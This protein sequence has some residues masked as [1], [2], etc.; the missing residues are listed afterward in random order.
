MVTP[1]TT[2]LAWDA[3]VVILLTLCAIVSIKNLTT[4]QALGLA[5][6]ALLL[7]A[8]GWKVPLGRWLY[9][10]L[11][12]LPFSMVALPLLFN[13]PGHPLYRIGPLSLT[14]EG[15]HDFVRVV[16]HCWLCYQC[17][18]L[19]SMAL[20]P[21]RFVH[22]LSRLGVPQRLVAMLNLTLRYMG[23]LLEEARR[24]E[25][26]RKLRA[27]GRSLSVLQR[28]RITGQMA[29]SLF[30]RSLDRAER[31]QL[32]MHCRGNGRPP[33]PMHQERSTAVQ[34]AALLLAT[35]GMVLAICCA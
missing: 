3:R 21:Q 7:V 15:A 6:V 31:V 35:G 5:Q 29:G 32:A 17:L 34:Y 22:N 12:V 24:M 9:R 11:L 25:R 23:L 10:S 16:C 20:G 2:P 27:G 4:P 14:V 33:V 28:C 1:S 19:A 13:T 30:L 18:L 26:A 8:K